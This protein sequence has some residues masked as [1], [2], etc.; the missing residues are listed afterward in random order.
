MGKKEKY[1]SKTIQSSVK[2][3]EH[4][5]LDGRQENNWQYSGIQSRITDAAEIV[6]TYVLFLSAAFV[7]H[8]HFCTTCLYG[9]ISNTKEKSTSSPKKRL[10]RMICHFKDINLVISKQF[11]NR[12]HL[13]SKPQET[14][15]KFVK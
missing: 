15:L 12:R 4:A 6:E 5:W 13:V 7:L 11:S 8:S 3:D 1:Y 2:G 14:L 9:L 10:D